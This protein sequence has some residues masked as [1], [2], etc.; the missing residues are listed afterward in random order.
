MNFRLHHIAFTVKDLEESIKWYKEKLG[1]TEIF[2]YDKDGMQFSIIQLGKLKLELFYFGNKTKPLPQERQNLMQDLHTV[3]T[4]H[5]CIEV[6][7]LD[8]T[9]KELKEKGVEFVTEIDTAGFGGRY[10]FLKDCNDILIE[11]YQ[12][13]NN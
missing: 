12:S 9:I 10:I 3:G 7:N 1:A 8:E 5:L 6:D 2:H 13:Q 11:L 4:K